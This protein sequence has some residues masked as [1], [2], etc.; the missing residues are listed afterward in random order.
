MFT[1][2][3]NAK[4]NYRQNVQITDNPYEDFE[5]TVKCPSCGKEFE[6]EIETKCNYTTRK[7]SEQFNYDEWCKN[8]E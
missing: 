8:Q 5:G 3:I 6:L 4:R 7:P 1:D 2:V